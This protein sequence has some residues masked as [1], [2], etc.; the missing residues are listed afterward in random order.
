MIELKAMPFDSKEITDQE[1][2]ET[3]YDRVAYSRDLADWMREYFGNGVLVKGKSVIDDELKVTHKSGLTVQV[4]AGSIIINGRTG[5]LENVTELTVEMG[6]GQPRIDRIIA[7]LNLTNRGVQIKV[8]PGTAAVAPTAPELTKTEDIYQMSLAQVRVN[9]SSA[10]IASVTDERSDEAV[11]GISNVRIGIKPP[12]GND[13]AAVKLSAKT[14]VNYCLSETDA[15]VDNALQV[16]DNRIRNNSKALL[17]MNALNLLTVFNYDNLYINP[18]ADTN[19]LETTETTLSLAS[20][21]L[22]GTLLAPANGQGGKITDASQAGTSETSRLISKVY[23][24]KFT[25][26]NNMFV[27]SV[28]TGGYCFYGGVLHSIYGAIFSVGPNGLPET[29]LSRVFKSV[30]TSESNA[31]YNQECPITPTKVEAGKEYFLVLKFITSGSGTMSAYYG[32][33]TGYNLYS[34]DDSTPFSWTVLASNSCLKYN[35]Y[36]YSNFKLQYTTKNKTLSPFNRVF[37]VESSMVKTIS[38]NVIEEVWVSVDSGATYVPISL[39]AENKVN[40]S[41]SLKFRH[42][43]K[44]DLSCGDALDT[45]TNIQVDGIGILTNLEV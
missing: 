26:L 42:V 3:T 9:A 15:Y 40:Q 31:F 28:V 13:A 32:T 38:S 23:A 5:W 37:A 33:K 14:Q 12:T 18:L 34:S 4:G 1:T 45:D 21:K 27:T 35:I 20:G 8:L 39:L 16:V 43:Y 17:E 24:S 11:C 6:G 44:Y 25:A 2:G 19:D 30:A 36:G 41:T 29:N 7:E 22:S 10:V